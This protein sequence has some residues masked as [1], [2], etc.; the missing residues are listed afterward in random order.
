MAT[1]T[2]AGVGDPVG[3]EQQ[4]LWLPPLL[5]CLLLALCSA[6]LTPT[7][8]A[9]PARL[10]LLAGPATVPC[11]QPSAELPPL[12]LTAP[13]RGPTPPPTHELQGNHSIRPGFV[14]FV[15]NFFGESLTTA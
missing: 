3:A 4:L 10:W 13:A 12:P 2:D 7:T 6:L 11:P 15:F 5:Q 9:D 14:F 1:S 8:C